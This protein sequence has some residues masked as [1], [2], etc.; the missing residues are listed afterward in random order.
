MVQPAPP[1]QRAQAGLPPP[2]S[3]P[4]SVPFR[5]PSEHEVHTPPSQRSLAQSAPDRHGAPS[6]QRGQPAA[7]PPQSTPD[8]SPLDRPSLQVATWQ[9]PSLQTRL[10]QSLGAV[11]GE[12]GGQPGHSPPPQSLRT[13]SPFCAPSWQEPSVQTRVAAGQN[14]P[15]AQSSSARHASPRSHAASQT[16][17]QS[18]AGSSWFWTPSS[19]RG[20]AQLAS[21]Q[22]LESQSRSP[23]QALPAA[24]ATGQLSPQSTAGSRPFCTPSVQLSSTGQVG[25]GQRATS[26]ALTSSP[27][28]HSATHAPALQTSPLAQSLADVQ[29]PPASEQLA[30]PATPASPPPAFVALPTLDMTSGA[31]SSCVNV[32]PAHSPTP[33]A[34]TAARKR[35]RRRTVESWLRAVEVPLASWST[36]IL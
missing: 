17:P 24:H 15:L 12:P 22:R 1:P 13:S 30:D 31:K 25:P 10:S 20:A 34:A 19:Q 29:H 32:Q 16:P 33:A 35:T 3:S 7:V 6:P 5:I 4:V 27:N 28:G 2:Q 23:W 21:T 14:A 11:Q 36:C 8:S 18:T 26:H 9:A